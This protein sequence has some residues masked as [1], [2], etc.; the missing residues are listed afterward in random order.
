MKLFDWILLKFTRH[1][2]WAIKSARRVPLLALFVFGT[3]WLWVFLPMIPIGILFV[4]LLEENG[5]LGA[6]GAI[7]YMFLSTV[8]IVGLVVIFLWLARWYFICVGLM[9][10]RT[11]MA[12]AKEQ[13]VSARLERLTNNKA[14]INSS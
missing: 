2:A 4:Y 9:F 12:Q 8:A 7:L 13:E 1:E 3:L 5:T 14:E 11:K 10:G 6:L